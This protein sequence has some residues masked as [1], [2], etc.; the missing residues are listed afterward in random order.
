MYMPHIA[1]D[2]Q[3]YITIQISQVNTLV[4]YSGII[5]HDITCEK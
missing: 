2:A 4:V 3:F 5:H 1:N